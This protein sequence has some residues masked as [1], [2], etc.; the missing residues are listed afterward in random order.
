MPDAAIARHPQA[1]LLPRLVVVLLLSLLA[2]CGG[3]RPEPEVV[4]RAAYANGGESSV[5]LLTVVNSRTGAGD[6][7]ALLIAGSQRVI[8]DPAGSFLIPQAP[9]YRDVVYGV[10]PGVETVYLGY[11]ARATHH[12]IAQT[13]PLTVA[14]A[15]AAIAAA[16]ARGRAGPGLC[17]VSSAAVLRD[18]P[19]L[20]RLPGSYFPVR[21]SESFGAVP[22]VET[23]TVVMEDIPPAARTAEPGTMALRPA[24]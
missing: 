14:A 6:H 12:V 1:V 23:R 7:A 2:A 4:S 15:D 21:L 18:I 3:V 10:S 11:H 22:G 20:E 9:R 13:L 24:G 5:T 17:A 8:Y 19:G 16:E